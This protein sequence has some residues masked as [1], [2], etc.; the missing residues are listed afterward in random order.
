[1]EDILS[2]LSTYGYILLFLYS[3]GGGFVAIVG[4]GVLSY[5]GNMDITTSI[6]VACI[7][8]IIGDSFL[9]YMARNNK[10][11]IKTH[12]VKHKRKLALSILWMRRKGDLIV[13]VQKY[14]YGVKTLIPIVMGMSK[15]SYTRFNIL[16]IF[17][18][19]LWALVFGLSGYYSA[20]HLINFIQFIGENKIV[21]PI[22]LLTLLGSIWLYITKL[23][24]K[25]ER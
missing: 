9:F 11:S 16:N 10:A 8:N 3:F 13:F 5:M 4:A 24:S 2:S 25:K 20:E 12:L 15:Y 17:A 18:S 14:I 19:I 22:I 23:T 1:M 21:M 6:V 7:A